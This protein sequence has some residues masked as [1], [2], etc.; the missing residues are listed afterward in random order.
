MLNDL[1]YMPASTLRI[2]VDEFDLR[3]ALGPVLAD[4]PDICVEGRGLKEI[5]YE[6]FDFG[7]GADA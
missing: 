1:R 3:A 6:R 5:T 2:T 4:Y 7:V